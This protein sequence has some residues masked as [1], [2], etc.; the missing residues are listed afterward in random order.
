MGL[1][2]NL[3]IVLSHCSV[4]IFLRM[5]RGWSIAERDEDDEVDINL[6]SELRYMY[7][8]EGLIY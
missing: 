4:P 7:E 6:I 2:F 5:D 1:G 8:N 3:C